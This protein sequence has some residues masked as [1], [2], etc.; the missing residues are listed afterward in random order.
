MNATA[1]NPAPSALLY[2]RHD[3]VTITTN[4]KQNENVDRDSN[5]HGVNGTNPMVV[6]TMRTAKRPCIDCGVL[7]N[8]TTRCKKHRQVRDA[9][10]NAT[11]VHYKGNYA[12]RA[13]Q[14]RDTA[15]ICHLCGLGSKANDPWTAD[16]LLPSN[17]DSM[18]VAAHRSC[19]SRRGAKVMK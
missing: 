17:V 11:R 16:H 3:N 18:L 5:R 7:T 1:K 8:G 10:R 9:T 12:R 13:R 15:V 2:W 19:N 14:V 6:A 4:A